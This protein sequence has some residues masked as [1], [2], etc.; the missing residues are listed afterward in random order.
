MEA[1]WKQSLICQEGMRD[2]TNDRCV[3]VFGHL[4]GVEFYLWKSFTKDDYS[5]DKD[6]W[7]D[8]RETKCRSRC[9]SNQR[10]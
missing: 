2:N 6:I 10:K 5:K 8:S 4:K 9:L 1:P 7:G 3:G